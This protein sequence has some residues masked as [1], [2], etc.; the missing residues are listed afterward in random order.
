MSSQIILNGLRS[1]TGS[2]GKASLFLRRALG[3]KYSATQWIISVERIPYMALKPLHNPETGI[4]RVVGL[5]S[6]SGTN[7][8]RI[9]ERQRA[10]EKAE[11][12]SPFEM[13][14]IFS[15]DARSKAPEIGRDF[16]VPVLTH[17]MRAWY[18]RRNADRRDLKLRAKFDRETIRMLNPFKPK[19]AAFGGYMAVATAPLL[20]TF[21]GINVHP[22]DL[23]IKV[24]NHRKYT[25]DHAVLDAILTGDKTIASSTHIVE[26]Q[27]DMGRL[28]MISVP[29]PVNLPPGADMSDKEK[30]KQI[31]DEHQERLKEKGDWVIFPKTIEDI[32]RGKYA[33]DENGALYYD[34]KPIPEGIRLA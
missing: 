10:I 8:R 14:I 9:L 28:L 7:L 11:G 31:A 5:M 12:K 32:A 16:A 6:G 22:A 34:G 33:Q 18:D 21:I 3:K 19:L 1:E 13:V 27:V 25:G 4:L 17:D 30:A 29:L 20:K 24:G 23:S 15:N 26:A 2:S